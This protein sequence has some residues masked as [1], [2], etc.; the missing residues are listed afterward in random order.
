MKF[1]VCGLTTKEDV[2]ACSKYA[3]ALGF[4][5]EYPDSPRSLTLEDAQ[6]LMKHV[7][8]FITR[9]AVVPDFNKAVE[10]RDALMPDMIQLHG[11]ESPQEVQEFAR[12]S[13]CRIIKA[14]GWE[15]ASEFT[16]N[17][18]MILIDDKY[19]P[20]DLDAISTLINEMDK[21]DVQVLI[22]GHISPDN[23]LDILS[24]IRPYGIDVASGVESSPGKKDLEF[25]KRLRK[26]IDLG[27]TVGGIV[28]RER[29]AP[30]FR[31]FN[32]LAA[33]DPLK[34]IT[35]IKP[36]SPSKGELR[37]V[38]GD[39]KNIV[40][41]MDSGGA[42]AISVLVEE[43]KFGGSPALLREVR[44]HTS[45]PILAKGF[46]D[47]ARQMAELAVAGADGVLL[48]PRVLDAKGMDLGE[49]IEFASKL[50]LDAL[51]EVANTEEL[52][53]AI[54][55]GARMIQVNNR[56]IYGD[57]SIDLAR[58]ELGSELPAGIIYISASGIETP[59][60]IASVLKISGGRVDGVLVGTSIMQAE[61]IFVKVKEL[62]T[63][64][65]EVDQ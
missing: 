12:D 54:E 31:F 14:C 2:L 3:D 62:T 7:P 5:V 39:L 44:K 58:S 40:E 28:N 60:D 1:K 6:E 24:K 64:A 43:N 41:Q 45:L 65:I 33:N 18:D 38:A 34:V 37:D 61:N 15:R 47:D 13:R 22:A 52:G 51:V 50:G 36:S 56:D 53:Q 32:V 29:T 9:V 59:D 25:V 11:K 10:I 42:S 16:Q 26:S 27:A 20:L 46:I 57:L 21:M 63:S 30:E 4:I 49:M 23:V 8:P 48:M 19:S 17:V 35:E 55:C